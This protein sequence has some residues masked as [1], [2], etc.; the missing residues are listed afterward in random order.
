MSR[1]SMLAATLV[2]LAVLTAASS[3]SAMYH[4]TVGRWA[5][6]DP[7]EYTEGMGLYQYVSASPLSR[8]DPLGLAGC[9]DQS[10]NELMPEVPGGDV[11][12]F[13]VVTRT[14][15]C[16]GGPNETTCQ[17]VMRPIAWAVAIQHP[18]VMFQSSTIY[19]GFDL[20]LPTEPDSIERRWPLSRT[21]ERTLRWGA[22]AGLACRCATAE[23]IN[24]CIRSAPRPRQSEHCALTN[25]CQ[26]DVQHAI[27]GC[28]LTGYTAAPVPPT[29]YNY[30]TNSQREEWKK[31]RDA[32]GYGIGP[33]GRY[34]PG[35]PM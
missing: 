8:L 17:R 30:M 26:Q 10:K 3:A 5:A 18:Y 15:R 31:Q 25:N 14:V 11:M 29:E 7:N 32:A 35:M 1:P 20:G 21:E 16:T 6:R 19:E 12:G 33:E 4:P 27:N 23:M 2:G 34:P 22:R 13:E 9:C 28:C 24:N